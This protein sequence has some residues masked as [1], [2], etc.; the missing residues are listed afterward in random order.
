MNQSTKN[1]LIGVTFFVFV[2][3]SSLLHAW[4]SQDCYECRKE[5]K[6]VPV[7]CVP[8]APITIELPEPEIETY[9]V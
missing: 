2:C 1:D 6:C 9:D 7:E 8:A 4:L 3:V 5:I